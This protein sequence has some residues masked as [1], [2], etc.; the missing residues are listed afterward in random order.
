MN[1][2][3]FGTLCRIYYLSI[4]LLLFI[5]SCTITEAYNL[6]QSKSTASGIYRGI[7]LNSGQYP[8]FIYGYTSNNN[9]SLWFTKQGLMFDIHHS[10]KSET[11]GKQSEK[12]YAVS[13]VFTDNNGNNIVNDIQ[14]IH[15]VGTIQTCKQTN[16]ASEIAVC[17]D[18]T[19]KSA[20]LGINFKYINN[21]LSWIIHTPS[22]NDSLPN[23]SLYGA[24]SVHYEKELSRITIYT[25]GI[26][27][28]IAVPKLFV[29]DRHD[30]MPLILNKTD[31]HSFSLRIDSQNKIDQKLTI[32]LE[33]AIL[34]GG[35]E[36]ESA[37]AIALDT[38][39]NIYITGE[40]TSKDFPVSIGAY[41]TPFKGARDIFIAKYDSTGQKQIFAIVIG[42]S[43]FDQAY[44]IAVDLD[45]NSYI[46]GTTSSSDFPTTIGAISEKGGFGDDDAF[47]LKISKD[48][49][50]LLYSTFLT[51]NSDDVGRS[52]A[53][54]YKGDVFLT[55]TTGALQ[56]KLHTFLK[57]KNAFDTSYNGGALDGFIAKIS[58]IGNGI[59]DL[60]YATL[61]GGN[62]NDTPHSISIDSKGNAYIAG[63]TNS[64]AFPV[65]P[66]SLRQLPGGGADGFI[67]KMSPLGDSLL[68]STL[69]AGSADD[70]ALS[71]VY[72]EVLNTIFVSGST[73]SDGT[74]SLDK[75]I[76]PF[77]F[78][79]TPNSFDTSYNGGLTDGFI[80]KIK[81]DITDQNQ[82]KFS[83]FI[84]GK[85]EDIVQS[86]CIDVCAAVYFTGSTTS[87]DFPF[88]DDAFDKSSVNQE[89]F[90]A[91]LG[92][93]GNILVFSSFYG[94]S[95]DDAGAGITVDK[96][97]AVYVSGYSESKDLPETNA[98]A[99]SKRDAFIIKAQVGILPLR[100]EIKTSGPVKFCKGGSVLLDA[101][102]NNFVSYQWRKDREIIS[103]AN[104]ATYLANQKGIYTVDVMDA[105]GCTGSEQIEVTVFDSP[106]IQI[107]SKERVICP[108]D[109]IPLRI[110][111]K[112]SIIAVKWFSDAV[113]SCDTCNEILVQPS[114]T[115]KYFITITDTNRCTNTDSLIVYVLDSNSLIV[116][117]LQDTLAVCPGDSIWAYIPIIN[118]E[119]VPL[120]MKILSNI[121][122][123]F[124]ILQDSLILNG[125][126]TVLF[127]VHFKGSVNQQYFSY[128][129]QFVNQCSIIKNSTFTVSVESPQLQIIPISDTS[130]CQ[131][132]ASRRYITVKNN[133]RVSTVLSINGGANR[134]IINPPT[135]TIYPKD[136]VEFIVDFAG[137]TTGTYTVS[138]SLL[139]S[140]GGK[141]SIGITVNVIGNPMIVSLHQSD[142]N[143]AITGQNIIQ[144]VEIDTINLF[145]N[146]TNKTVTF[147]LYPEKTSLH[148][149]SV[150]SS[151]CDVS[152]I[153]SIDSFIITLTNCK[154]IINPLAELHYRSVI[155]A[156]LKPEV[157]ITNVFAADRCISAYPGKIDTILLLPYGCE[158]STLNIYS[159]VSTLY[160][161]ERNPLQEQIS[162]QY[163]TVEQVPVEFIVY[164]MLGEQIQHIQL[165]YHKPGVYQVQIQSD[166]LVSGT[167]ILLYKAGQY[168][169]SRII[170]IQR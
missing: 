9:T 95:L 38:S 89:S 20:A 13:L 158:L 31:L 106:L 151:S 98:N 45:G 29:K 16:E 110:I 3:P 92:A 72:D 159:M 67:A 141:D 135:Q 71:I 83:S 11:S 80:M 130:I 107:A 154:G 28:H 53:V 170:T 167:Y 166:N 74:L 109:S 76:V 136:S 97:G 93:L 24:D 143:A 6:V 152:V 145:N 129:V 117:Q 17:D 70:R 4:L 26:K 14:D 91:K 60:V 50:Q 39:R 126:D 49:K 79:T 5:A 100:P 43:A 8:S 77:P 85:G 18:I 73:A 12:K 88:T 34:I 121:N 161:V 75:N 52:I 139:N 23:I 42:G 128:T 81:P 10:I 122:P 90:I 41:I 94:G 133:S 146:S 131:L 103:G 27:T 66:F 64:Q 87:M 168:A 35:S 157:R 112:D 59:N 118:N 160:S 132:D 19:L 84:G 123:L 115:T 21:S 2:S 78:P 68:Y 140:C 55:G 150:L 124:S 147:T 32:P 56:N 47:F 62:G 127:P 149:D 65:T 30:Y 1:C 57:T 33:Y 15:Q 101:K 153:K 111:S 46:T 22:I 164:S 104:S 169:D 165:P 148:L 48:G 156:T 162:I 51:G 69:L 134:F 61:I 120:Q 119:D 102:S 125:K 86:I 99:S 37:N 54:D 114:K 82:I 108:G 142:T 7:V 163:S 105:S 58:P 63:E 96:T 44:A 40:T 25:G 113:L 116:N 144:F 36:N 137:D 155:G 138:Y